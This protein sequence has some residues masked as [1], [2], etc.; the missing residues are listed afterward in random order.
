M[1]RLITDPNLAAA[2]DIYEKLIA[3][4]GDRPVLGLGPSLGSFHPNARGAVHQDHRRLDLV[5]VLSPRSAATG[6][7]LIA[8]PQQLVGVDRCRVA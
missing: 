7:F 3:M 6:P 2:D 5:A 4:H 1:A 8:L